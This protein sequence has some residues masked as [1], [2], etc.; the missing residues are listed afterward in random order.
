MSDLLNKKWS[1]V[2]PDEIKEVYSQ[3][4]VVQTKIKMTEDGIFEVTSSHQ[5]KFVIAKS[6]ME[7]TLHPCTLG[8]RSCRPAVQYATIN[9]R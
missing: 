1:P 4:I 9:S 7:G 3:I 6:E 8:R 5:C 2:L